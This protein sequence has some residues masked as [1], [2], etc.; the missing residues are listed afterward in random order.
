M[1]KPTQN[2]RSLTATLI[3][4]IFTN[5]V[6]S[7]QLQLYTVTI[8]IS[9]QSKSILV[10]IVKCDATRRD[11]SRLRAHNGARGYVVSNAPL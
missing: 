1:T 7:L 9:D 8:D 11:L 3:D 2:R 6:N 4:H 10:S 5:T